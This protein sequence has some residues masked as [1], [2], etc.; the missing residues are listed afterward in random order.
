MT[1]KTVVM[2]TPLGDIT[3]S[4]S[5]AVVDE[6]VRRYNSHKALLEMCKVLHDELT[7]YVTPTIYD[8]SLLADLAALLK[9]TEETQ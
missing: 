8:R 6:A 5:L 3:I 9:K 4:G 1:T 2:E 7:S